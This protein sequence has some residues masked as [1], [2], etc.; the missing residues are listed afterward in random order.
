M[1]KYCRDC[2]LRLLLME[3]APK[4]LRGV[5]G[6]QR[7]EQAQAQLCRFAIAG[8]ARGAR[9]PEFATPS[10]YTRHARAGARMQQRDPDRARSGG[11]SGCDRRL[12]PRQR[13]ALMVRGTGNPGAAMSK[14]PR[15]PAGTRRALR[16]HQLR[17]HAGTRPER[18]R[19]IRADRSGD[20]AKNHA[21]AI[22]QARTTRLAAARRRAGN[23]PFLVCEWRHDGEQGGLRAVTLRAREWLSRWLS[24]PMQAEPDWPFAQ[25][26]EL[27]FFV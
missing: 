20:R 18:Q 26:T 25:P 11:S 27:Q 24:R 5:K 12:E 21:G 1:H 6:N 2:L 14:V 23:H 13:S 3:S 9:L 16:A 17:R 10:R 8:R 4:P 22:H 19:Q 7:V 15:Y